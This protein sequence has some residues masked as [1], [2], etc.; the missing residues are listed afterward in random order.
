[1]G[2]AGGAGCRSA[3]TSCGRPT[4][5]GSST[6]AR[7]P[8]VRRPGSRCFRRR[9]I[10]GC[11]VSDEALACVQQ[12]AGRFT[13]EE[14]FPTAA[15]PRRAAALPEAA[16]RAL[17]AAVRDAR[18]RAARADVPRVQGDQLPRGPR[19][20]SQV[21]G[22]RAHAA[23]DPEP[24][25]AGRSRRPNASGSA[26]CSASSTRPSCWCWRCCI[27]TSAS[28]ATTT[29][30]VES[31]RMARQM[32]ERLASRPRGARDGRVPGRAA[33]RRCRVVAFRRDT[34]DPEIVRQFAELVGVEERL[35]MLCLMTLADVEAVSR[36]TLTPWKEELLW[37]LY[38]DT[39]NHLTLSY[40]DEVID[41]N[42]AAIAEVIER[43]PA[44]LDGEG[45]RGV[46]PGAAAPLSAAVLARGGL[47]AR[48]AVARP[49]PRRR[50]RPGSRR[51]DAAWELTVITQRPAVP[52]LEH[53]RRAVVVRHGHPARLRLHE[54]G[55]P[56]RRHVPLHRRGAV[57][58]AEPEDG[59]AQIIQAA[60]GR[61][62]RARRYRRPAQGPRGGRVPRS[63]CP[64]S[65]RSST[66]TT[67]RRAATPSSRSSRRTRSA[68]CTA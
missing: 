8:T 53:L 7:R 14:F 9:S 65:R 3:R 2:A 24:R 44:D 57:P 31:A 51:S 45:D 42:Q 26:A 32:F 22:R 33:P 66:A 19:L 64:A 16:A 61:R 18:L 5:S 47:S 13:A 39:Y 50:S 43:R 48:P 68:C 55:R 20:L 37:R 46:P 28:G 60:R 67:T 62:S 35:K 36:E 15:S 41:R 4:A 40:G 12:N 10:S 59:E 6:A 1:M 49:R 54:A 58:R 63:A 21:H 56:G 38:V 27:T 23:D 11:A 29:I 17:R 30:T 25:A 34:E 52:V